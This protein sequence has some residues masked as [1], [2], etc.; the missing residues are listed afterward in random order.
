MS[1]SRERR[2]IE[3]LARVSPLA[4]RVRRASDAPAAGAGDAALQQLRSSFALALRCVDLVLDMDQLLQ[5]EPLR[6]PA[7]RFAADI[8]DIG[9]LVAQGLLTPEREAGHLYL[10]GQRETVPYLLRDQPEGQRLSI[11]APLSQEI[12]IAATRPTFGGERYWFLC[13]GCD[14]RVLHLYLP[15][16]A[17]NF[18]CRVCH[19]IDRRPPPPRLRGSRSVNI[20]AEPLGPAGQSKP[21]NRPPF[22][23]G[24]S[25]RSRRRKAKS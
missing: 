4:K 24:P 18:A 17:P 14:R 5:R 22:A 15:D 25:H 6:H 3:L 11:G 10:P 8:L 2:L 19:H 13:P 12:A 16:G 23:V 9:R 20:D 7:P 21:D 1:R